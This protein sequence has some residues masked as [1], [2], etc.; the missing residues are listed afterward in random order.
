[1]LATL[2]VVIG[3]AGAAKPAPAASQAGAHP[4]AWAVASPTQDAR[5]GHTATLLSNGQVLVAGGDGKTAKLYD[6]TT[7]KW[8]AAAPMHTPRYVDTATLLR[9]GRVRVA[10]GYDGA[11]LSSAE[12]YQP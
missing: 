6:P 12:L 7:G 1:M 5:A 4:F 11:A 10:G 9:S 8:T 3:V 2:V